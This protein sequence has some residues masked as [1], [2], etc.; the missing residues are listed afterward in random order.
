MRLK[1]ALRVTGPSHKRPHNSQVNQVGAMEKN[2]LTGSLHRRSIGV[3]TFVICF[4]TLSNSLFAQQKDVQT[5]NAA[6]YYSKAFDLLKYPASAEL[7]NKIQEIVKNGWKEEDKELE[8]VL[9]ENKPCFDEFKKGLR[10]EKCDFTFGKEYKHIFEK[11]LP[12]F[13]KIKKF[14]S[15]LLLKGR[16]YEKQEEFDKAINVYLS[17]L[18]FAQH[19]SQDNTLVSKMITITIESEAYKPIRQYLNSERMQKKEASKI[20]SFFSDFEKQHFPAKQLV[21]IEK[22]AFLSVAKMQADEV[23]QQVLEEQEVSEEKKKAMETLAEELTLQ[24]EEAADRYYGNYAIAVETDD[25]GDWDFA[26]TELETLIKTQKGAFTNIKDISSLFYN[27]FTGN[28]EGSSNII[29]RKIISLLLATVLPNFRKAAEHY[30][31]SLKELREIK[32]LAK[33]KVEK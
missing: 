8:K 14:T 25:E 32:S 6:V 1:I 22:E 29:A 16:H 13:L 31:G 9:T 33:I 19:I 18:T 20:L 12:P 15:L 27:A 30:Y 4:A 3:T 5:K 26:K 17:L 23:K 7:K 21:E 24:A 10:L 2:G 11:E 28:I